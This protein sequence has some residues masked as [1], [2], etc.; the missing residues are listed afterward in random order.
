MINITSLIKRLVRMDI[1]FNISSHL[2]EDYN[3]SNL[4]GHKN[5]YVDVIILI[6]SID[7]EILCRFYEFEYDQEFYIQDKNERYKITSIKQINNLLKSYEIKKTWIRRSIKMK[8]RLN[9]DNNDIIFLNNV[10]RI[11]K[12]EKYPISANRLTLIIKDLEKLV[13]I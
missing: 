4:E 3:F 13:K 10:K 9:L 8:N 2:K 11:L 12:R 6:P 5:Y 7:K 1:K